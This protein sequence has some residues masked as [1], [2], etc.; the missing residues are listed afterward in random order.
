MQE[1][2]PPWEIERKLLVKA[3]EET[4]PRYGF[5]PEERPVEEYIRFGVINL[6]KPPG[7]SSHEVTAWTK[8]LLDIQ[9]AGHGGT[10]DPKVTGILP[11]A[12]YDATKI[13]Q[14]LLQSGKEYICIMRL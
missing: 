12:L 3:E 7:P 8:R 5:K 4:S 1:T 14:A 13:I 2:A 9:R 10:L 6:D 11:I